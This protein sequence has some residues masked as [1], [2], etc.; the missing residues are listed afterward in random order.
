[1]RPPGLWMSVWVLV[2]SLMSM[3]GVE[4]GY[5]SLNMTTPTQCGVSKIQWWGDHGPYH[6][7]LTPTT[8]VEH[9]YNLWLPSVENGTHAYNVTLRQPAGMQF[10]LTVWGASGIEYAGT[11]DVMTVGQ[12]ATGV[13]ECFLSD[14]EILG[15]YTFSFNISDTSNGYPAQCSNL[16]MS[17]PSSLESNITGTVERRDITSNIT[18]VVEGLLDKDPV[19]A[20]LDSSSSKDTGNTT[21]P[22]TMFGVIPLGNSFEIPITFPRSSKFAKDLP[23][24]YL[25]DTPTTYT[26]HGETHLNWTVDLAKGTRFI[27]VAGIGSEEQ[28][29][30]GGSS[31]M[32]TVGQGGAGCS[33][34]EASGGGVPSV[35]AIGSTSAT[36]Q[37][38]TAPADPGESKKQ[39]NVNLIG[40]VLACVFSILATL[41]IVGICWFCRRRIQRR[42]AAQP[43]AAGSFATPNKNR[44]YED[45]GQATPETQLDL[46][47]S[48]DASSA[49]RGLAPLIT[50]SGQ[51]NSPSEFTPTIYDPFGDASGGRRGSL[52]PSRTVTFDDAESSPISSPV[53]GPDNVRDTPQRQSSSEDM[54]LP[55]LPRVSSPFDSSHSAT[56]GPLRLHEVPRSDG[57]EDEEGDGDDVPELKRDILTMGEGTGTMSSSASGTTS[58]ATGRRIRRRQDREGDVEY[59]VHRDA[60]RVSAPPGRVMELPPRYEEVDWEEGERERQTR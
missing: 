5:I 25:S 28:W 41:I 15:Q 44:P 59:M 60:G 43:Q 34:K 37:V 45:D 8:F 21:K 40:T 35:T 36:S 29:A 27:L 1:M 26:S 52:V 32:L 13:A 30:S 2:T 54:L 48:R 46:I 53:R 22:P 4:A 16:S 23:D 7:L 18:A 11:T 9:G 49:R 10:L 24:S 57:D 33:G 47:S 14:E 50:G 38:S 31:T 12:P 6:I 19:L 42:R 17:W 58:S 51:P 55:R 56:R 39:R 20:Q 3:R